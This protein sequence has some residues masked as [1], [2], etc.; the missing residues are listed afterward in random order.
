LPSLIGIED[1]GEALASSKRHG[2]SFTREH[3]ASMVFDSAQASTLRECQ[4]ITAQR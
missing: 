2:E 3:F 1:Q 4:S